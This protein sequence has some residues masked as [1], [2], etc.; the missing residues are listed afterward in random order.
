[1]LRNHADA[2][3]A[4]D[5]LPVTD[6]AFR[7]L[8]AFFIIELATRRVVHVSAT[9][10]PT[11][12]WVARQRRAATPFDQR[13]QYLIRDNDGTFGAAFAHVAAG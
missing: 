3:W 2:I 7:P 11:D 9:R 13:P 10:H 5:F 4:C 6:L 12:T 1:L 8:C